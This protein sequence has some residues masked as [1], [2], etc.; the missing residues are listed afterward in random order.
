M[1]KPLPEAL[2]APITTLEEGKA[3]LRA[4]VAAD[5]MF[6][7]EDDPGDIICGPLGASTPLFDPA[8][9]ALIQERQDQLYALEWGPRPGLG[10][11][12]CPIG[13]MMRE[14]FLQTGSKGVSHDQPEGFEAG[15]SR[16]AEADGLI[17]VDMLDCASRDYSDPGG[18]QVWRGPG[19]HV[20][21]FDTLEEALEA[22]PALDRAWRA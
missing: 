16:V 17:L 22:F 9:V 20:Q 10:K 7:L 2:R 1:T 3:W 8:D 11:W 18:L 19:E 13:Y 21:S 14:E 6:H 15:A 12:Y 5:L 4:L